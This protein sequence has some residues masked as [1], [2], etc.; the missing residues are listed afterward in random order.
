LQFAFKLLLVSSAK[1]TFKLVRLS[2]SS[3]NFFWSAHTSAFRYE[4]SDADEVADEE[5]AKKLRLLLSFA[6]F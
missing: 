2:L 6:D 4:S 1:L 3:L 5:E